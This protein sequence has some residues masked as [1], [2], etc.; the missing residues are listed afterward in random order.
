MIDDGGRVHP[1]LFLYV[2]DHHMTCIKEKKDIL[3]SLFCQIG[4][5]YIYT[6]GLRYRNTSIG[7]YWSEHILCSSIVS[8]RTILPNPKP[9][10]EYVDSGLNIPVSWT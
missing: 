5:K 7:Q 3:K 6:L 1:K 10:P 9:Y 4:K 2:H 8:F